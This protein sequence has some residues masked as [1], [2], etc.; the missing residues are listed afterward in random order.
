MCEIAWKQWELPS[1]VL[2]GLEGHFNTIANVF[3]Y[4]GSKMNQ[5]GISKFECLNTK[6][7]K[8]GKRWRETWVRP[9]LVPYFLLIWGHSCKTRPSSY[10]EGY[11][12]NNKYGTNPRLAP[13]FDTF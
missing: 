13:S 4:G 11:D 12:T 1:S 9:I 3:S 5:L 10:I 6:L 7:S 2:I 8:C